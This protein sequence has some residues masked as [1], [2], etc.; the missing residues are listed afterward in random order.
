MNAS[1]PSFIDLLTNGH[2]TQE[3]FL[4]QEKNIRVNP[5]FFSLELQFLFCTDLM[6][7]HYLCQ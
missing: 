6:L 3:K 1:H 7:S 4:W 2:L 5:K